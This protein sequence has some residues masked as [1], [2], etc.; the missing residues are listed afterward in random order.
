MYGFDYQRPTSVAAAIEAAQADDTAFLA[1]GMTLLPALKFRLARFAQLVDLGSI[2]DLAGI[3]VDAERV[4]IG[5]MTRHVDVADS[6]DIRRVLPA[7]ARLAGGIG[8]PLVRNRG[9]LGGSIANNDPAADYPGAVLGLGATVVTNAR[10]IPAEKFFTGMFS[11]ALRPREL[12]TRVVFPVAR[13]AAYLKFANPASRYAMVGVMVAEFGNEV[14]VAVTG[15]GQ[16]VFRLPEFERALERKFAPESL[17]GLTV[18]S[19]GLN[20]DL[21]GSAQYRA[22]L[23][24]VVARRAVTAALAN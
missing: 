20:D 17:E 12:I 6:A 18:P 3:R 24:N 10:E 23:I 16:C 4:E 19:D 8:D 5:A 14:R 2:E 22:H 15:A 9:T 1:G 21:H 11:T 13:R 7:L